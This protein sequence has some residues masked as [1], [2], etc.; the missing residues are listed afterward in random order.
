MG[1][2]MDMVSQFGKIKE[3]LEMDGSDGLQHYQCI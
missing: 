3:D 1:A 2:V